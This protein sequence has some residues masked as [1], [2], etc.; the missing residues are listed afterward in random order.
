MVN[1]TSVFHHRR[2]SDSNLPLADR[3][4]SS[5]P[6]KLSTTSASFLQCVRERA[7]DAGQDE[8]DIVRLLKASKKKKKK[9]KPDVD[10]ED[11]GVTSNSS[12]EDEFLPWLERMKRLHANTRP[13]TW[14]RISANGDVLEQIAAWSPLESLATGIWGRVCRDLNVWWSATSEAA[15]RVALA[16]RRPHPLPEYWAERDA[17]AISSGHQRRWQRRCRLRHANTA[18]QLPRL[19]MVREASKHVHWL[20]FVAMCGSVGG[21]VQPREVAQ[22]IWD[23]ANAPGQPRRAGHGRAPPD[24]CS[25]GGCD[26]VL[27]IPMRFS[28][29]EL[30]SLWADFLRTMGCRLCG[31]LETSEEPSATPTAARANALGRTVDSSPNSSERSSERLSAPAS[32]PAAS[33]PPPR[34]GERPAGEHGWRCVSCLTCSADV[35]LECDDDDDYRFRLRERRM[36]NEPEEAR[37]IVTVNRPERGHVF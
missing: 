8:D 28:P 20:N 18:R 17:A 2:S 13:E 19:Q 9:K 16:Q 34:L 4:G 12:E 35:W 1:E 32:P 36:R 37:W 10:K 30:E 3:S 21:C 7:V 29:Q 26:G 5:V 25:W 15:C 11:K 24:L 14:A 6:P 22:F 31:G 27:S 33:L 23:R